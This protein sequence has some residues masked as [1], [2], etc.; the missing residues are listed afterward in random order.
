[1]LPLI[2][3]QINKTNLQ[4][5]KKNI[6]KHSPCPEKVHI[7]AVTK[8][9]SFSTLQSAEKNNIFHI[10]EN[11]IQETKKKINKKKLHPKTKIHLIGHLQSNKVGLAVSLY[12]TIQ[13]VDSLK[14]I[15]RMIHFQI[16]INFGRKEFESQI[17]QIFKVCLGIFN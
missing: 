16:L 4:R 1:M 6:I 10:G 3:T 13:S 9:F 7:I 5:V 14:I 11:K 8:T 12:D 15:F 17:L 2:P